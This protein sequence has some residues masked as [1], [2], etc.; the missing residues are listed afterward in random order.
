[1]QTTSPTRLNNSK[2][3]IRN[4]TKNT[5]EEYFFSDLILFIY[6]TFSTCI[7]LL[8]LLEK[9]FFLFFLSLQLLFYKIKLRTLTRKKSSGTSKERISALQELQTAPKISIIGIKLINVFALIIIYP[10]KGFIVSLG[11]WL[12]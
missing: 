1:L 7:T 11:Q 2:I 5:L 3:K 4:F 12:L 6:F 9:S 8:R 10:L